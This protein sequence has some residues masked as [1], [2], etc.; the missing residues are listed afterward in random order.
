MQTAQHMLR[1][2]TVVVL[3]E[4]QVQPDLAKSLAIPRL[5]EKTTRISEYLRLQEP[6]ILDFGGKFFH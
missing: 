4:I 6:R 1:G 5:E 3:D 2:A